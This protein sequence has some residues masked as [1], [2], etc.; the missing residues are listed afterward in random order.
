MARVIILSKEEQKIFST[1]SISSYSQKEYYLKIPPKLEKFIALLKDDNNKIYFI[2]LYMYYKIDN[3]F[4]DRESFHT[5][6]IKYLIDKFKVDKY[7]QKFYLSIRQVHRY[8]QTIKNYFLIQ[9]YTHEIKKMLLNE[10]ITMAN[11]FV[12]RKKIFYSLV[13]YSKKLKIEVPSYTELSQIISIAIN[14]QK[15][16]ILNK[17]LP[18]IND[19]KL[20]ILDNF[21]EKDLTSK[22]RWKLSQYKKLEQSSNKNKILSSL[23]KL[24]NIKSKF[25]ITES[26]IDFSQN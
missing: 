11:N 4:Y 2:L 17:L 9:S 18:Y 15:K 19:K 3:I 20:D 10:A 13:E 24:N 21:L 6:D 23:A 1:P 8:K 22:N 16:T 12:H 25:N 26:I 14:S 5:Q 7:N